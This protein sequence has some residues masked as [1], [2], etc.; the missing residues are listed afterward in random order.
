MNAKSFTE[1]LAATLVERGWDVKI[2]TECNSPYMG[3]QFS[4]FAT[5]G[6]WYEATIGGGAYKSSSTGRWTF[7]GVR[8]YRVGSDAIK[9]KTYRDARTLVDVFGRESRRA[10][11]A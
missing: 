2:E 6:L 7:A 9:S 11:S 3:E 10:V 1:A 5:T 8:V 4:F